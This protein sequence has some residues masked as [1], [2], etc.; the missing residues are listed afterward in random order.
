[1]IAITKDL[2]AI[3]PAYNDNII[4]FQS[5]LITSPEKALVTI[6]S[7]V[8][9]I[10]PI[11]GSFSYNL[12][13]AVKVLINPTKFKDQI[14]PNIATGVTYSDSSLSKTVSLNIVVS[15]PQG[16]DSTDLTYSFIKSAEQL[17]GYNAK[18][19]NAN[20]VRVFLSSVNY[21]DYHCTW[22]EGYPFDIAVYGIKSG[23]TYYL[24]NSNTGDQLATQTAGDNS[25]K[26][27]F[28][29]DG[30]NDVNNQNLIPIT[31]TLNHLELH[32]NGVFK[33]NIYLNK[34]DNK[35]GTYLKW[36]N[37]NGGYSYWLFDRVHQEDWKV[38]NLDNFN[39]NFDNLQNLIGGVKSL[40]KEATETRK[41][42]TKLSGNDKEYIKDLLVSPR[43]QM[44][45]S[46]Q[47]YEKITPYNFIDVILNDGGFT[48]NNSKSN[49]LKMDIQITLPAINTLSL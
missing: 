37:Q 10:F 13:E 7:N 14:Q 16:T 3:N 2:L 27:I 1:M 38:T 40:G 29:S 24:K 4:S 19:Q 30:Q 45:V 6:G 22:Y 17:P 26:R 44:Y 28:F 31:T 34:K 18:I 48:I 41:L 21:T 12:K 23:D 25:V 35:C 32:I 11:N 36:V 15:G 47:P 42:T 46:N 9:T 8:F 5:D 39:S 49:N 33:S 20:E 43:V